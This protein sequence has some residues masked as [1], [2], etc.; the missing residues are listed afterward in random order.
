MSGSE[1]TSSDDLLIR[2]A[3]RGEPEAFD[4]L[5]RQNYRLIHR[6]ALVKTGDADDADDATQRVLIQLFRKL[7]TF[8]GDAAFGTWL[9][10]LAINLILSKRTRIGKERQRF[11]ESDTVLES[12][13]GRQHQPEAAMDIESAVGRLPEGARKVFVLHDVEGYRHDE[14]GDLLGIASGTSK[15]QLHRA[16]MLLRRHL[17]YQASEREQR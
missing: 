4:D 3:Q 1:A 11:A 15:A 14:I 6:W 16:R 12:R 17:G 5:I 7:G 9:H 10:R 8:R 2:R 13:S